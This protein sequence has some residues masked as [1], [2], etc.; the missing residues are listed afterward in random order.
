MYPKICF[1]GGLSQMYVYLSLKYPAI[2]FPPGL[3]PSAA[4]GSLSGSY[5]VQTSD[6]P[7]RPAETLTVK[8]DHL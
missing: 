1:S 2:N 4:Y 7:I 3:M 8:G 6:T 5:P